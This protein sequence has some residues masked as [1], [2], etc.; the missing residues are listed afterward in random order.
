LGRDAAA[1]HALADFDLCLS[2]DDALAGNDV[3]EDHFRIA[4]IPALRI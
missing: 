4:A 1:P 2:T 3:G